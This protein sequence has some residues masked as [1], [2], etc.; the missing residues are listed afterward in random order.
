MA[1]NISLLGASYTDVPAVEL[2]KT[3]GGTA[4]FVDVTDTTAVASDVASGKYFYTASGVRVEGIASGG[5]AVISVVDSLDTYGGTIRTI[6]ATDIS[7]TTAVASDVASGKYF[8]TAAGIK[9]QGT[10]SGGGGATEHT[11]HLELSDG[12]DVDIEVDYD[13]SLIATMITSYAPSGWTYGGKLVDTASLDNV[14]WFDRNAIP[15]NTELVVLSDCTDHT[16]LDDGTGEILTPAQDP[17]AE[18]FMTSDYIYI[19]RTMTFT[20]RSAYWF[21]V[22]FYDSSKN[23]LTYIAPYQNGWT[24]NPGN[25]NYGIGTLSS[26][27]IPANA[28][29]VKLTGPSGDTTHD[30]ISLIR[31][32]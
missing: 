1:Q 5:M 30:Y 17:N 29:Y 15:L 7:D 31:T 19:D 10:G 26:S 32:A 27:N 24:E 28:V 12:T 11:I 14:K 6:T 25:S 4:S 23:Y 2:P 9:T 18:W 21:A 13:D 8:Y 22:C 3:G 20:A 16:I